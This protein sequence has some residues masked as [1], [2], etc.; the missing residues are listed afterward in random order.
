MRRFVTSFQIPAFRHTGNLSAAEP[1]DSVWFS[2]IFLPPR[3]RCFVAR[4]ICCFVAE[5]WPSSASNWGTS[6]PVNCRCLL[7]IRVS[8]RGSIQI[9]DFHLILSIDG[10]QLRHRWC[11][12]MLGVRIIPWIQSMCMCPPFLILF[13]P[14]PRWIVGYQK[15]HLSI[16]Q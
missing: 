5:F 4:L 7:S 1:S 13:S 12:I 14:S 6:N 15:L 10:Q 8:S 11:Y 3:W 9:I 2:Q 16:W